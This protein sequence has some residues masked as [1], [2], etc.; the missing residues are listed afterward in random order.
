MKILVITNYRCGSSYYGHTLAAKLKLA[1]YGEILNSN[2]KNGTATVP[3][4]ASH[5]EKLNTLSDGVY[6]IMPDQVCDVPLEE[7]ID[8]VDLHVFLYRRDFI[9]QAKSWIAINET[10][11]WYNNG[12]VGNPFTG[13]YGTLVTHTIAPSQEIADRRTQQLIG[14]WETIR[15][16]YECYPSEVVCL[17]DFNY[18][19]PYNKKYIWESEIQIADYDTES[20]FKNR[21][22]KSNSPLL[23]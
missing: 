3:G 11:D 23:G 19:K 8:A 15:T 18:T 21:Q 17:E 14:N 2:N 4:T 6:K 9:A 10:N 16:V 22:K 20:I 5:R 13:K 1:N 7:W 12:L